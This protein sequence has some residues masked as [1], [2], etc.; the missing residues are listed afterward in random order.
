MTQIID[1]NGTWN[2]GGRPLAARR[3]PVRLL[4]VF[5]LL[6]AGV[7][8]AGYF[9]YQSIKANAQKEMGHSLTSVAN[10]KVAQIVQW[11]QERLGD[12]RVA[13]EP[14][15]LRRQVREWLR[16]PARG[17]GRD[18]LL[19]WLNALRTNFQYDSLFL[20]S[21]DQEHV[22]A[23]PS[24]KASLD[25]ADRD[26]LRTAIRENRLVDSNLYAVDGGRVHLDL[27]VPIRDPEMP[28]Q[29][30][31]ALLVKIDPYVFLYPLVQTWPD[32]SVTAESLIVRQEGDEVL[33]LNE[34]RHR[35]GTAFKLSL[36]VITPDLPAAMAVRGLEGIVSG[37][38]YRGV[39]VLA[40]LKSIPGTDWKLVSKV[41]ASE[42]YAPL[43]ERAYL[44]GFLVLCLIVACGAALG[45]ADRQQAVRASHQ[46]EERL[47]AYQ[48][49]LE[50]QVEVR[51]ADLI[52]SN[53]RLRREIEERQEAERRLREAREMLEKASAV[54]NFQVARMD[55][56]GRFLWVNPPFAAAHAETP[57]GMGGRSYFDLHE[58]SED[59]AIFQEVNSSGKPHFVFERPSHPGGP[60]EADRFYDWVLHPLAGPS[61]EV[62]GLIL[63]RVDCTERVR[64]RQ[65]L[66]QQDILFRRVVDTLPVGL[67]L[68][69][70][71][72]R[73]IASNPAGEAIWAGT[74]YVGTDRFAEYKAWWLESGERIAAED[75]ALARAV[76][77]GETSLNEMIE[78]E[79]F[80]GTR[81]IILNSAIPVSGDGGELLGAFVVIQDITA[82]REAEFRLQATNDLLNL[83]VKA[84]DRQE[85]LRAVL[86][87][88][89]QWTRAGAIGI[90]TV[91]PAGPDR[92][93]GRSDHGDLLW[94]DGQ[95]RLIGDARCD[96]FRSLLEGGRLAEPAQT[97]AAGSIRIDLL[98]E[99]EASRKQTGDDPGACACRA[100]GFQSLALVAIRERLQPVGVILLADSRPAAFTDRT[101]HFLEDIAPLMAEALGKYAREDEL[102]R[103]RDHLEELVQLRTADLERLNE[104]LRQEMDVRRR[105]EQG[106]REL[107][108][109]RILAESRREWQETFDAI[110]DLVS[111]H[112]HEFTIRRANKAFLEH[113]GVSGEEV[114]GKK[115]FELFHDGA[116][117]TEQCPRCVGGAERKEVSR[118]VVDPKSGRAFLVSTY[119]YRA[120][121]AALAGVIHIARDITE[122]K[123]RELK[124]ILS[125]RLASLGQMAAGIAHEINNPLATISACADGLLRRHREGKDD[126]ELLGEYLGII[127]EEIRRCQAITGGMLSFVRP[128][129]SERVSLDV[130]EAIDRALELVRYQGRLKNVE[131]VREYGGQSPRILANEGAI[132]QVLLA[133][134]VNAL[135]AMQDRGV[136]AIA[137]SEEGGSVRISLRDSGPGVPPSLHHRIFDLFFT[138]KAERGGTGL[139]LPIA[140]QIVRAN[141]GSLTFTS[142]PGE[143]ATFTLI[144]PAAGPAAI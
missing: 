5:V 45:W 98:E 57:D 122:Q 117:P 132:R 18:E 126:P 110:T 97:T 95:A 59:E 34:L 9:Y 137:V 72:G 65:A 118:E 40:M 120:G 144:F 21:A 53:E 109:L 100:Y 56:A 68:A 74:R 64:T 60:G 103:Y 131:V 102:G 58:S 112:D 121:E 143:G 91:P 84:G 42:I 96:C 33:F 46:E 48:V 134:L 125:E 89:Q 87:L 130:F 29:N 44:L 80:D 19:A 135:D 27:A 90:R 133:L 54:A 104:Q 3:G 12:A 142:P 61:G 93:D 78:I 41:D 13:Q 8:L 38:D 14:P 32:P 127:E 129:G 26:H 1:A 140:H 92:A 43:Q 124:L 75:W 107:D 94:A 2:A 139:G 85:Y 83:F 25:T 47:A 66:R 116:C 70:R 62:T 136:L 113:F 69:D 108:R 106:L 4:A 6:A 49:R 114:S 23:V 128:P 16:Q 51:T 111:I 63:C 37:V 20:V 22:L 35:R 76:R 17:V 31:A 82:R 71:H 79:A 24:G 30:L 138:T 67:Y 99:W 52:Q 81:K 11:R 86:D 73:I 123:E 101:V 28:G 15:M 39:L 115:C 88:L 77:R 119:P 105:M 10:L 36:P 7:S 141:E 50:Q 55:P